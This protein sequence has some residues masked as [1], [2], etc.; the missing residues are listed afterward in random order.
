MHT[1]LP[2]PP[3]PLGARIIQLGDLG[4]DQYGSGGTTCFAFAKAYLDGFGAPTALV[5]GNHDLEGAGSGMT[6]VADKGYQN[7]A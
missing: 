6:D 2:P 5:L 3:R 7:K 4:H 1:V